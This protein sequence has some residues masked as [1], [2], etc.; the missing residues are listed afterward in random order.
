MPANVPLVA[1]IMVTHSNQAVGASTPG[2]AGTTTGGGSQQASRAAKRTIKNDETRNKHLDEIRKLNRTSLKTARSYLSATFGMQVTMSAMLKQ[3]QI[4]T[5]IMG[6]LFSLFGAFIDVILAPFVPAIAKGIRYI[7]SLT[8]FIQKAAEKIGE[9]IV[10]VLGVLGKLLNVIGIGPLGSSS[11]F[12]QVLAYVIVGAF[13]AR[14][15]NLHKLVMYFLKFV[16]MFTLRKINVAIATGNMGM[17][18]QLKIIALNTSPVKQLTK[19]TTVATVASTGFFTKFMKLFSWK[20]IAV[21]GLITGV[22]ALINWIKDKLGFGDENKLQNCPP[23]GLRIGNQTFLIPS[24]GSGSTITDTVIDKA[25]EVSTIAKVVK[26]TRKWAP[27]ASEDGPGAKNITSKAPPTGGRP[28]TTPDTSKAPPTPDTSKAPPTG[29]GFSSARNVNLDFDTSKALKL[30]AA[31]SSTL[32]GSRGMRIGDIAPDTTKAANWDK[33]FGPASE[34]VMPKSK[35]TQWADT[36]KAGTKAVLLGVPG[37]QQVLKIF[38]KILPPGSARRARFLKATGIVLDVANLAG[39]PIEAMRGFLNQ[40]AAA[41]IVENE[42]VLLKNRYGAS[43]V[44][45]IKAKVEAGMTAKGMASLPGPFNTGQFLSGIPQDYTGH[46]QAAV[47]DVLQAYGLLEEA[48]QITNK[49]VAAELA[50]SFLPAKLGKIPVI[51][52]AVGSFLYSEAQ[53]ELMEAQLKQRAGNL[54][55]YRGTLFAG[56]LDAFQSSNKAGL[57]EEIISVHVVVGNTGTVQ[58]AQV[59]GSK[60][61][62]VKV[63]GPTYYN[64][65]DLG[66]D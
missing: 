19:A 28:P 50:T 41:S 3:S 8:P 20:M 65:M 21:I 27:T 53:H 60:R 38:D 6:S 1:Q 31:A 22:V 44:N 51:G 49:V 39:A 5:G 36:A 16:L 58:D 23:G 18:T 64:N 66:E 55:S 40:A 42:L 24:K 45:A 25:A 30:G 7:A 63:D 4:F 12:K 13:F 10:G 35:M 43:E 33:I 61:A 15:F 52:G 14:I 32:P 17:L 37:A 54:D 2:R 59:T 62:S 26:E 48:R 29:K 9:K 46:N 56:G 57:S 11:K 34:D 47:A